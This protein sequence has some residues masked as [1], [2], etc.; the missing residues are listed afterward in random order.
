M[1]KKHKNYKKRATDSNMYRGAFDTHVPIVT[2]VQGTQTI[3]SVYLTK[4][5]QDVHEYDELTFLL[6]NQ[7]TESEVVHMYLNTPGG[8]IN[9]A[10]TI[11]NSIRQCAAP[12]IGIITGHVASAG[13]LIAMACDDIIVQDFA[14]FLLHNYSGG[15]IGTGHTIEADYKF[16]H[17]YTQM[18][19]K[20]MYTHFLDDKEIDDLFEGKD[21][22]LCKNSI[23]TR[24]DVVIESRTRE[25]V[26]YSKQAVL[27]GLPEISEELALIG[28]KA[29]PIDTDKSSSKSKKTTSVL[30]E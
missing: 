23:T 4:E 24:W 27:D 1:T 21:I 3:H 6:T 22:Y 19:M 12:V 17:K 14:S 2:T 5:I 20:E 8:Y 13:T 15:Y 11:I 18:F 25:N 10:I 9:S 29:V 30:N 16:S 7:V 26:E 28:Y